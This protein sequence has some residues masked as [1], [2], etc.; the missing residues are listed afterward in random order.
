MSKTKTVPCFCNTHCVGGVPS[1]YS[2][3]SD[4]TRRNHEQ[5]DG[6]AIKRRK[7]YCLTGVPSE[8]IIP[9]VQPGVAE[10][11]VEV[12]EDTNIQWCY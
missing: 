1:Q 3:V 6:S 11:D 8:E 10:D 7:L 5:I 9:I 12:F 2:F 4:R